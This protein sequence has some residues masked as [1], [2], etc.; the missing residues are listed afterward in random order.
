[1]NVSLD[2]DIDGSVFI[3][4]CYILFSTR[5]AGIAQSVQRL[6]TGWTKEDSR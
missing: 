2:N 3:K 4:N 1:M 6:A 5:E